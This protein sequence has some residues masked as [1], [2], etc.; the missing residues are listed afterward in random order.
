[1]TA[2]AAKATAGEPGLPSLLFDLSRGQQA[3]LSMA[4]PG[5]AAVLA[6]NDFSVRHAVGIPPT[7]SKPEGTE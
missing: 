6:L 5:L 2:H 4:H 1:M 3:L 7:P